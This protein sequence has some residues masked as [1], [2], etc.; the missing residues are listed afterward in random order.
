[1][2]FKISRK[3]KRQ[4]LGMLAG[5]FLGVVSWSVLSIPG[6]EYMVKLGPMNTGHEELECQDCHT[7]AKG[8]I[9][10]QL[11]ANAMHLAGMRSSEADFGLENVDNKKCLECHDRPND[12]HPVHRF[13]EPRFADARKE[14]KITEC[15]TCHTEHSGVRMTLAT[16]EYCVN[17]HSD[18]KMKDDPLDVPH[19]V[20]I[21]KGDWKTCLQCHDFHGNHIMEAPS[22]MKDTI[23]FKII[24]AYISG[25]KDPYGDQKK[26]KAVKT[27][28]N[29]YKETK[30]Y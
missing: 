13:T 4:V 24:R 11:Q 17:C 3:R 15:E 23:P 20:L 28:D 19:D 1:M 7:K 6:N 22:L 12:R 25:G 8:N 29:Q 10:Q 2:N 30:F 5:A 16:T 14:I 18:L 26:Y 21:K 9:M 27:K